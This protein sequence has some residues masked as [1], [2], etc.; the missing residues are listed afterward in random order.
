MTNEATEAGDTARLR[1]RS[2]QMLDNIDQSGINDE[3]LGVGNHV[4][5]LD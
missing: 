2:K 5:V 4:E 3:V 1:R